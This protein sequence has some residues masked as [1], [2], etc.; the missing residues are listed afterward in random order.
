MERRR[1]D[2]GAS[3]VG[4][5]HEA[6]RVP[7]P[8]LGVPPPHRVAVPVGP[9]TQVDDLQV[10]ALVVD[11]APDLQAEQ[12]GRFKAQT[13]IQAQLLLRGALNG[14]RGAAG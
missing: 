12:R 4:L 11:D 1:G 6:E 9:V 8:K 5:E 14:Q 13:L 2:L 3:V 7:A 10:P